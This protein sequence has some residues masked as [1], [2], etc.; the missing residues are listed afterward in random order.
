MIGF[1]NHMRYKHPNQVEPEVLERLLIKPAPTQDPPPPDPV[2]HP[3]HYGGGANPYEAIKVIQAWNL[4]FELG[5]VLKYIYRAPHK[6]TLL[7]DLYKAK[8]YLQFE[9]E[10]QERKLNGADATA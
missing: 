6:G 5:N 3:S 1:T 4:G 10:K 9:I 7:T 8:Q 2:K